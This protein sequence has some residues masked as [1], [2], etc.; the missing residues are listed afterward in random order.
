MGKT[1]EWSRKSFFLCHG[2]FRCGDAALDLRPRMA[3][4]IKDH[5]RLSD[6]FTRFLNERPIRDESKMP[7]RR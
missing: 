1:P 4:Q 5:F 6:S 7:A 3:S 2:D